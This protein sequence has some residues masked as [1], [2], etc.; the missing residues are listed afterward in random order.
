[1]CDL[2]KRCSRC[3]KYK[4]KWKY[5][6]NRRK[7]DGLQHQCRPCQHEYHNNKWYPKNKDKRVKSVKDYKWRKREENYR[8][9][10]KEYFINGCVDCGEKNV[11][12]LEF[13]HV[14]GKKRKVGKK[15]LEGVSYMIRHGYKWKTIKEEI[16]KCEVRCRNCHKERTWKENNYW[17][18]FE[19]ITKNNGTNEQTNS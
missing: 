11:R 17:K 14:R 18:G 6:K 4:F 19:D 13:D 1:V 8:R 15:G 5:N 12:V 9:V 3:K 16:D 2:V 7:K 10:V